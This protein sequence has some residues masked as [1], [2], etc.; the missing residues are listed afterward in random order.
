MITT[1]KEISV[2]SKTP[3]KRLSATEKNTFLCVICFD[4]ILFKTQ[5]CVFPKNTFMR[6]C[7]VTEIR[8]I[9]V[10]FLTKHRSDIF[11]NTKNIRLFRKTPNYLGKYQNMS[12]KITK[13]GIWY[14][15]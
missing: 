6:L 9:L 14:F 3:K 13:D 5:K 10:F 2:L 7:P 15:S 12:V 1:L 4:K 11:K 8:H